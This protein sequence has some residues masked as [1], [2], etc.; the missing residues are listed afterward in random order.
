M[1]QFAIE[2]DFTHVIIINEHNKKPYSLSIAVLPDQSTFEFRVK[3]YI[4]TY[5]I[6]NKGNPSSYHPE[7]IVKNFN[8]ALGRRV[9]RSLASLFKADPE[10]KGRTVVTFHNQRDFI[11]FRHHRYIFEAEEIKGNSDNKKQPKVT[12]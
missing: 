3:N 10:F 7:I 11:F 9:G 8:T 4:P 5:E 2:K 12:L 6:Y 1:C